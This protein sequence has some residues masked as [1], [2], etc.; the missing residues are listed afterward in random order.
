LTGGDYQRDEYVRI[1]DNDFAWRHPENPPRLVILQKLPQNIVLGYSLLFHRRGH[2]GLKL[3][4]LIPG[5]LLLYRGGSAIRDDTV[6][7]LSGFLFDNYRRSC[8]LTPLEL[9]QPEVGETI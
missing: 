5:A 9:R 7:G 4:Q 2:F 3:A 1:K 6:T 8:R